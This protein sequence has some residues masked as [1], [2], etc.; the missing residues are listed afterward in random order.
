[1]TKEEASRRG[2]DRM[3]FILITGDAYVDHPSFGAAVISRVLE[4]KGFRIGIIAQPD[5]RDISSFRVLGRPRLAFLITA[6]NVDSMVNH[7]SV[8]RRRRK[9]DV[10]SPGGKT[11]YRPDRATLVYTTCAKQAYKKVPVILGGIEASLRRFSHY[12]YWSDKIRRSVLV[13]SKADLLVY[14]MGEQ[15]V[16]EVAE[17]LSK[18][19]PVSKIT[20]VCGTVCRLSSP[21]D[22]G[23]SN[24]ILLPSFEQVKENRKAFAESF[25]TQYANTDPFTGKPLIE[26]VGD[27]YILQNPPAYPLSGD[28]LDSIYGLP[29]TR[30]AHPVYEAAGGVPAVEEITFSLISSR[31]C[32]GSCNF[33]ALTFHQGKIVQSRSHESILKE[34]ELLTTMEGFKGNIHDVG[35]PTANFRDPACP[36]QATKGSCSNKEC[37]FPTRCRNLVVDHS[38]YLSLLRK[39]REIDGIK[40]VFIRSGIRFDYLMAD[41]D[42]TFFTEL[43]KYHVSGQLKVAPEHISKKVLRYMGK[44]DSGIFDA[45]FNAFRKINREL[46]KE[47]YIVPY[48]I[49]SHP[50]SSLDDAVELAEYLHSRKITS[51]QV[52][53]F[54]PTPGTLSTCMYSTGIDPRTG[55][56][57]TVTK[58]DHDRALQ[59][60]LLQWRKPEHHSLILEALQKTNR[61]DL[62]GTSPRCLIPPPRRHPGSGP[63]KDRNRSSYGKHKQE[64]A[65]TASRTRS[66]KKGSRGRDRT[67]RNKQSAQPSRGS[68]NTASSHK[69]DARS[70][71]RKDRSHRSE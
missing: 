22:L 51:K 34:A 29:Y 38:D 27:S 66:R 50:G 59:R 64:Q 5:W 48:F 71:N 52:Q 19:V 47:Q 6:G 20:S 14:G 56:Q 53:D 21:D 13:D 9:T 45:F 62:I 57:V 18:G 60:A 36:K 26:P 7:F 31:G 30:R 54:Y 70:R 39:I 67:S 1:M 43:C 35:G 33:C 58:K 63:A 24:A 12:D 65:G 2:W 32:F 49:S 8:A 16:S 23:S 55:E 68:R 11:G 40:N 61:T 44:P 37:L 17:Q 42:T 41:T 3:D 28:D 15:A 10:Y 46:N 25:M 4:Q 69:D